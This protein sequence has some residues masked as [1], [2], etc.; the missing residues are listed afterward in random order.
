MREK[1]KRAGL[2][3]RRLACCPNAWRENCCVCRGSGGSGIENYKR[4]VPNGFDYPGIKKTGMESWDEILETFRRQFV[5]VAEERVEV[6]RQ[7]LDVLTNCP[8]D[9]K[10][11]ADLRM[12]F[13]KLSGTAGSFG[14]GQMTNLSLEGELICRSALERNEP[15]EPNEQQRWR[16]LQAGLELEITKAHQQLDIGCDL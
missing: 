4:V 11:L 16:E 1:S 5:A 2:R 15:V 13:H 9:K 3:S 10:A 12:Q 14:Y 6:I 8:D 7:M